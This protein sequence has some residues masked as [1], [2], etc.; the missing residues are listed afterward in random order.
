M[1]EKLPDLVLYDKRLIARHVRKGLITPEQ[2]EKHLGET[3]DLT[4]KADTTSIDEL[5][6]IKPPATEGPAS[7]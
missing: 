5:M 6:G 3:A 1:T 4:E 2:L 7:E